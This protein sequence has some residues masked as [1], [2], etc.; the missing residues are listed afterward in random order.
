MIKLYTKTLKEVMN[1]N[2]GSR[3]VLDDVYFL[4]LDHNENKMR[5]LFIK[6]R[7]EI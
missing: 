6:W 5:S 2:E 7:S 1:K 3:E 4:T